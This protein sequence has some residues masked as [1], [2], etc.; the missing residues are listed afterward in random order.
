MVGRRREAER[1]AKI[2]LIHPMIVP[3]CSRS[4][5]RMIGVTSGREAK[6]RRLLSTPSIRERLSVAPHCRGPYPR[7]AGGWPFQGWATTHDAPLPR[8]RHEGDHPS[9]R[10]RASGY[11]HRVDE[12]ALGPTLRLATAA[13][14]AAIDDL[15]KASTRALFPAFYNKRQTASAIEHIAHVDTQLIED[16]TYFVIEEAGKLIACGGWS[17]RD[18]LFTGEAFRRKVDAELLDP[19]TQ[20]AGVRAMF[21]RPDRTRRGLGPGSSRRVGRLRRPRASRAWPSRRRFPAS[22][23]TSGSVSSPRSNSS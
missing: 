14:Q 7:C 1:R 21:V 17:R 22:S 16:G 6:A 20:P 10:P 3:T 8:A 11:D 19:A 13:D 15:M 4:T 2:G 9:C 5:A 12:A 18:K 23:S